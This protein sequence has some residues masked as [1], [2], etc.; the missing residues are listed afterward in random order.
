MC[1][2]MFSIDENQY[3]SRNLTGFYRFEYR[4]YYDNLTPKYINILKNTLNNTNICDLEKAVKDLSQ[5]LAQEIAYILNNHMEPP[6][7]VCVVP[8]SKSQDKYSNNQLLFRKTIQNI[9]IKD[10]DHLPFSID[11]V[12]YINRVKDTKTTHLAKSGFGGDGDMP[13]P[14]ISRD[15]CIFSEE[16]RG[17]NILLIDDIYTK[18]INIIEDFAQALL[19][20]GANNVVVY[21]IG[22]TVRR[23]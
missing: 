21:S 18:T 7:S 9:L 22:Y 2:N 11:G 6:Y 20:Y 17:K 14:G 3:L 12:N 13:Y 1:L 19:D 10:F 4:G 5:G 8:R 23:Y 15:T 16:I